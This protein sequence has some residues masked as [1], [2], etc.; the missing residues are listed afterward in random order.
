MSQM[1]PDK[2]AEEKQ[3]AQV[4]AGRIE[5]IDDRV[6][7][8][9]LQRHLTG[10]LLGSTGFFASLVRN[11]DKV[12]TRSIP[13]LGVAF[14]R[15]LD[16]FVLYWNPDFVKKIEVEGNAKLDGLGDTQMRNVLVHEV[17]HVAL[18]HCTVRR[19]EP[20]FLW[21]IATDLAINS[22]IVGQDKHSDGYSALP[23]GGLIPGKRLI[24][25]DGNPYIRGVDDDMAVDLAQAVEQLPPNL[26][27]ETYFES[28][29]EAF[30]DQIK[31]MEEKAKAFRD[32]LKK[33]LEEAMKGGGAGKQPGQKGSEPGEGSCPG[34]LDDH[35]LWD[36]N[37]GSGGET[38]DDDREYTEQRVRDLLRR[39]T[40]CAEQS[41]DGWGSVPMRVRQMIK[42]YL[43][44]EVDWRKLLRQWVN[45]RIRAEASRSIRRIDRRYP[46]IHPGQK[47]NHRP[48]LLVAKDQSGS[49]SDEAI[50]LF[51]A[52]LDALSRD[53]DF[54][55]VD[56]DTECGEVTRW[57]RGSRPEPTRTR[58][59]GTDFNAPMR[60]TQ[61]PENAGRWD[62]I[63]YF[64]DGECSKP[65]AASVPR[66]WIICP[67]HK[68]L[69][70]PDDNE[71][72][73]ELTGERRGDD[74]GVLG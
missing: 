19:R 73:I 8:A 46:L 61:K 14:R 36:D 63:L 32:A 37:G 56:F 9:I 26:L 22:M 35:E 71:T 39:A 68:L 31:E 3:E 48:L 27:S 51:F 52:E 30:R 57:N 64:T 13:T 10:F 23:D 18:K 17:M 67:G 55:M 53:T 33:A 34:P 58:S 21:N 38:S 42:A 2:A 49:V 43:G 65:D 4:S 70:Q 41:S 25:S 12:C 7:Q 24:K 44:G 45:G 16:R 15:D 62:G 66:V 59:G 72:V 29:M 60:L 5:E 54:D 20:H 6:T 40:V 11:M 74:P 1:T 50:A 28:L 47:R 69:F